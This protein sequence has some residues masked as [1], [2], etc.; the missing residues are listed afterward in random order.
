VI[1]AEDLRFDF[2]PS[3]D[4]KPA[5][6]RETKLHQAFRKKFLDRPPL[7]GTSGERPNIGAHLRNSGF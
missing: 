6:E 1:A 4:G 3:K 2:I 5:K 7:D